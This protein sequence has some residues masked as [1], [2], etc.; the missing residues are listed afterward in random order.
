MHTNLHFKIKN[1]LASHG[2]VDISDYQ[3]I[4]INLFNSIKKAF[5]SRTLD[6]DMKLPPSR[7]LAQVFKISRSTVIKAYNLL[8]L[9]KY[10]KSYT[11]RSIF[12]KWPKEIKTKKI[13]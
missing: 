2:F 7:V 10:V 6:E 4:Y 5:I 11:S 1:I 13:D 9:E 12:W 8:V 3:N